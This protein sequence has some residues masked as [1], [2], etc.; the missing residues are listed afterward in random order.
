[1]VY[2]ECGYICSVV[3]PPFHQDISKHRKTL[4]FN[5][6]LSV[7]IFL[8]MFSSISENI[9]H[10]EYSGGQSFT[11]LRIHDITSDGELERHAV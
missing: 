1:M 11:L 7:N 8:Y 6:R 3:G 2:S 10:L 4:F 9:P 5:K